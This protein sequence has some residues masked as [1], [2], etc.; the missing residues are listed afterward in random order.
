MIETTFVYAIVFGSL[1]CLLLLHRPLHSVI[2]RVCPSLLAL[3]RLPPFPSIH[4]RMKRLIAN[5][6]TY[7]TFLSAG[8]YFDRWSRGDALLLLAYFAV[9]FLCFLVPWSSVQKAGR[10]AGV[11]ALVNLLFLCSSPY[12][13]LQADMVGISLRTYRRLHACVGTGTFLLCVFHAI[14]AGGLRSKFVLEG[15]VNLFAIVV[16]NLEALK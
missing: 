10:N 5:H 12:L 11:L 15:P 1:F 8:R 13:S 14:A 7:P 16:S 6:F 4:Q 3:A 2:Q 9:N